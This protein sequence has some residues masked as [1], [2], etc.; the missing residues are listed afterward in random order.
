[1]A[2]NLEPRLIARTQDW[3]IV[4]KPARWLSVPG[5]SERPI[6]SEWLRQGHGEAWVV[7]RL[8]EETSGVMLFARS[9]ASHRQAC[10]WFSAHAVRKVYEFLASGAPRLPVFRVAAAIEEKPSTTQVEV[11]ERFA[12]AGAAAFFG[13]ARPV[14]GRR[15]QIR[16][17][18]SQSGFP[19]WGD[20]RYGG[21]LT[22]AS[23]I[24]VGRVALHARSLALP[25]GEVFESPLPEDFSGWL[26]RARAGGSS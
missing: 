4:D 12:P 5:R 15:H 23:G 10:E 24:E 1:M 11:V 2:S 18:L 20:P 17:H 25:T 9:E 14:T 22:P 21:S 16:I 19:L 6:V 26:A 13:R 8:D 7:H 3:W